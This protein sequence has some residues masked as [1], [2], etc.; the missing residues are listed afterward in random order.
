MDMS[1]STTDKPSRNTAYFYP[2]K[3]IVGVLYPDEA[4]WTWTKNALTALWGSPEDESAPY[5]FSSLTDYYA[6][7]A[8]VLFRRFLSFQT[9]RDAGELQEWKIS[10]CETE[11]RSGTPRKV[12]V[13]PGYVNGARLVLASTKDHAHR[14]YI[15][16]GIHAEVTL[17]YR[18]KRW[19]PFDYTF[20]DFADGRYN[21]F[22]S[23][24][25]KRWLDEMTAR[26]LRND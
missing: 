4:L 20:P 10:A 3:L 18:R 26:R 9:L 7:I 8:P 21:D 15:G 23:L 19:T 12:N 25:R 13:D 16:G 22:L 2:V 24:V 11:K 6:D 5:L 1:V 17:R 14:I